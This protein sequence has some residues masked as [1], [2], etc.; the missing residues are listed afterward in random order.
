VPD[1]H[2]HKLRDNGAAAVATLPTTSPVIL[3]VPQLQLQREELYEHYLTIEDRYH[4]RRVVTVVELLS[5]A[6]KTPGP[7]RTAYL[8][9]QWQVLESE[10]H[11]LEIDLLRGGRHT[12]AV[13]E[14]HARAL[15]AHDYL[16]CLSRWPHR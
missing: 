13:P 9:K 10:C 1:L 8:T 15:G 6:N 2:V 12:L 3:E 7:G 4:D 11:L 16:I 14:A 5:P